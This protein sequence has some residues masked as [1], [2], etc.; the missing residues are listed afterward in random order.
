M[1]T[2]TEI[3]SVQNYILK[4]KQKTMKINLMDENG[5]TR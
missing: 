3:N 5:R 1:E 4:I 2:D